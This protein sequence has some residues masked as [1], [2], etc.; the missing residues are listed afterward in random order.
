MLP[1]GAG[2]KFNLVGPAYFDMMGVD[3][4][5][6]RAITEEDRADGQ[7]V[8]VVNETLANRVW[9]GEDPIGRTLRLGGPESDPVQV[10]GV[11]EDGKYSHV[12]ETQEP[13]LYLPFN[14]MPWEE[15]ML[16][17]QTDGDPSA[18]AGQVRGII[19]SLGPDTFILPQTTLSTVLRD[20]TYN[21]RLMA[22]APGLFSVLGLVLAVVG[23]YG[24]SSHAVQRRKSEIGIRIALGADGGRVLALVMRQGSHL[25]L[26]GAGFGIPAAAGVGLLLRGHLFG[27]SPVDPLSLVGA[28]LILSLA[29]FAAV[30][31]PSRRAASVDPMKV[32]RQE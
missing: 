1:Q 32:M 9:P 3:V 25:V 13:Y 31:P 5:R 12:D 4:R 29:T 10:V 19:R 16:L 22:L 30:L 2:V 27:V 23:L 24:V 28:T 17:A 26:F 21:W 11:A 15:V 18:L 14:Q 8:A 20:A 7:K 6:G